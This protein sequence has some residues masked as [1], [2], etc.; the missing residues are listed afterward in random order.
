MGEAPDDPLQELQKIRQKRKN[1]DT[2]QDTIVMHKT[3]KCRDIINNDSD[4]VQPHIT[5]DKSC[6]DEID[7]F[8]AQ[9]ESDENPNDYNDYQKENY[10]KKGDLDDFLKQFDTSDISDFNEDDW[11]R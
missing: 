3:K 2:A 4:T 1:F 7:A 8:F 9:F 6:D 11:R 5:V 10:Y